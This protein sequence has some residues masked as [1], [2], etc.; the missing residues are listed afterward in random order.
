MTHWIYILKSD[1]DIY[2]VGETTRLFRRFWEHKSGR[3]GA[4]TRNMDSFEIVAIYPANSLFNFLRHVTNIMK[5]KIYDTGFNIFFNQGGVF[6]NFEAENDYFDALFVENFIAEKLMIDH[7]ENFS[8]IRGGKYTRFD[9]DYCL[10]SNELAIELPNCK[11]GFPCDVRKHKTEPYLYFLCAKKNMWDEFR[12]TFDITDEPCSFFQKFTKD[13]EYNILCSNRHAKIKDLI[14]NCGW[15]LQNCHGLWEHCIGGCGKEYNSKFCV[16]Y[17][18]KA[19]N[20][21]FDCLLDDRVREQVK[22]KYS[23]PLKGKC[24]IDLT[25]LV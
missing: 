19:I 18:R 16:R 5:T 14:R 12:E 3:G 10:P 6:E 22:E 25:Q 20:F 11:C 2:Y 9:V 15:W 8:N 24:L 7:P 21:C 17:N 1:D 23:K 4:N 13:A